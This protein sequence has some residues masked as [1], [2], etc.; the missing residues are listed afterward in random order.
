MAGFCI[1]SLCG[2]QLPLALARLGDDNR[3]AAR[4]FAVDLVGAA[5]GALATSTI[6]IPYLGLGVTIGI[7]GAVKV[8]SFLIVGGCHVRP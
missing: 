1:A 4:L 3:A 7:L 6:L 8:M 5:F 2:F